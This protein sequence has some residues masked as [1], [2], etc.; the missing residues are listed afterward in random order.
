[1]W[2]ILTSLFNGYL[3]AD[4]VTAG[5][6]WPEARALGD[7][8][9][10]TIAERFG[11]LAAAWEAIKH[12]GYGESARAAA[13]ILYGIEEITLATPQA[14]DGQARAPQKPGERL[15]LLREVANI[16]HVQIDDWVFE[17]SPDPAGPEFFLYDLSMNWPIS[18]QLSGDDIFAASGIEVRDLT[19]M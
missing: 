16:D 1:N 13:R 11:P 17:V 4:F 6:S 8:E 2:D 15:R 7:S 9:A 14:A 12:T 10:G 18:M 19:T 5:A 3:P